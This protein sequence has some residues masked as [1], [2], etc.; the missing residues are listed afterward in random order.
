MDALLFLWKRTFANRLKR[1]FRKPVTYLYLFLLVLY[2]VILPLALNDMLSQFHLNTAEGMV[3]LVTVFCFW[4]L[5]ANLIAFAKRKGLLFKKSDVHFLF[6]TPLSPKMILLFTHAKSL[7][8]SLIMG[9]LILAAGFFMFH[10]SVP[11]MLLFFVADIIL[12]NILESSMMVLCYGSEKIGEKQKKYI[13]V[14]AY[15]LMGCF[16]LI[17]I[18]MY[19]SYGLNMESIMGFMHSQAVQAVPVV[20][21]YI[22]LMHLIFTGPTTFN[23][24]CS[25]LYLLSVVIVFILAYKMP[26]TGTYYEDAEKFADDYEEMKTKQQEGISARF[27]KKEKFGKAKVVYKG[28]GAKAIFYKQMLEYKKTKTFF[29]DKT[30]LFFVVI[31]NII[32]YNV[33]SGTDNAAYKMFVMPAVMAYLVICTTA[34]NGKW[35]KEIKSPYTFLLPDSPIRK[36]WYA[37]LLEHVKN[38]VYGLLFAVPCAFILDTP[39]VQTV[40][41]V[42]FYMMLQANKLYSLVMV[43]ALVGNILGKVG[44]QFFHMFLQMIPM[45][46]A[47]TGAVIGVLTASLETAYLFMSMIL[48]ACGAVFMTLAAFSFEKMETA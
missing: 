30:N 48:F 23:L 4:M 37:T 33:A 5:P 15:A 42:L 32:A 13:V 24:V 22:A 28:G 17:G 45:G 38:L 35:G 16:V 1:A 44:K 25:G 6:P 8:M 29:L 10:L 40:L 18:R 43:E 19:L 20:G 34:I 26:C 11:Q 39:I 21:W 14:L 41:C 7:G 36:L 9:I 27:G 47:F 12:E 46:L 2:G 31:G 3:V